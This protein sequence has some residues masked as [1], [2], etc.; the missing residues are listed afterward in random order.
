M[1]G[2]QDS[3]LSGAIKAFATRYQA[4]PAL[5]DRVTTALRAA[6]PARPAAARGASRAP[7]W[8]WASM[9]AVFASGAVVA[10]TLSLFLATQG[11]IAQLSDDVVA[12]HVRSLMVA[13]LTDVASSN[14]HTVKPWFSGK[15]DYTPPVRDLSREGFPLTGGRLDYLDGR[16]VAAL[17][18]RRRLHTINLF[19]WPC[20]DTTANGV[21]RLTRRGYNIVNWCDGGMQFWAVSDLN[22]EEMETFGQLLRQAD[23]RQ[24][25]NPR[26]SGSTGNP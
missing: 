22:A 24:F 2:D 16:S 8:Q 19:V 10:W 21:K 25:G 12:D 17:V 18:Y 3:E 23:E 15:L 4:P 9:G 26:A 6:E 7:W 13:H 20:D 5:R 1:N 11:E 14:Q